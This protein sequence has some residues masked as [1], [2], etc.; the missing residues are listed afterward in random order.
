MIKRVRS[1][2]AIKEIVAAVIMIVFAIA[3][4]VLYNTY[5][6]GKPYMKLHDKKFSLDIADDPEERTRGLS[7]R[8]SLADSRGMLFIY[9]EPGI[10][11]FWMK[12]MKFSIDLLWLD[13][14][15]KIVHVVPAASP[16]SYP[17]VFYPSAEAEYVLEVPAGTTEQ[18]G[19]KVG[20]TAQLAL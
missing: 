7:G 11:G 13:K 10:Y 20:D 8:E 4:I 15:L 14:D 19:I 2:L 5:M 16:D 12:E 3:C 9:D 18:L 6:T 1:L 17:S